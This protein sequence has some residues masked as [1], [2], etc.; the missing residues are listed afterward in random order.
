M[1]EFINLYNA[2]PD[3]INPVSDISLISKLKKWE[4]LINNNIHTQNNNNIHSDTNSNN[5]SAN[6]SPPIT[7]DKETIKRHQNE[8]KSWNKKIKIIMKI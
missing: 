1:K 2:N 7:F 3:S 4:S 6:S 8:H 5:S